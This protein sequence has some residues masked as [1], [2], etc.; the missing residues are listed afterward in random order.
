MTCTLMR[1]TPMGCKPTKCTPVREA[2]RERHSHKRYAPAKDAC[3]RDACLRETWEGLRPAL[4]HTGRPNEEPR[5]GPT[6]S[7]PR[8][9]SER[10]TGLQ[11]ACFRAILPMQLTQIYS[12]IGRSAVNQPTTVYC[13]MTGRIAEGFLLEGFV[14]SQLCP[15]RLN[16]K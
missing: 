8:P 12:A 11:R 3:P 13:K 9:H 6:G 1:C 7:K 15:Q 4:S 10:G 2:Y 14:V 5:N 16:A